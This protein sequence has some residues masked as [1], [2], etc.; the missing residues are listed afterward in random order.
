MENT[1]GRIRLNVVKTINYTKDSKL[2]KLR[3]FGSCGNLGPQTI[4]QN[5][6]WPDRH[7]RNGKASVPPN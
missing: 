7:G 2:S 5:W 3:D 1:I 4:C 6:L